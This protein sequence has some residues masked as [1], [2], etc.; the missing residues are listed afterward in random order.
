MFSK[1]YNHQGKETQ[2][3]SEERIS[4]IFRQGMTPEKDELL[5]FV[6]ITLS[7]VR[8]LPTSANK[9]SGTVVISCW[10]GCKAINESRVD[11]QKWKHSLTV[12]LWLSI[13]IIG[14]GLDCH[15]NIISRN[16]KIN[17]LLPSM[18]KMV[19]CQPPEKIILCAENKLCFTVSEWLHDYT[20]W[21]WLYLVFSQ[22]FVSLFP[23]F[24]NT[25]ISI[26]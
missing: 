1:D 26:Y 12:K 3:L 18:W 11:C 8:L 20:C 22:Y 2:R 21:V 6:Q 7:L 19:W 23:W 14:S 10:L 17:S 24:S 5:E 13:G 16:I 15:W 4:N 9:C 25:R